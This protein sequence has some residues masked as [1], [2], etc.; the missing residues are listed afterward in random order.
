MESLTMTAIE[1]GSLFWFTGFAV[2]ASMALFLFFLAPKEGTE[3][4]VQWKK[5]LGIIIFLNQAFYWVSSISDGTFTL[6]ESLPLHMCGFSQLMLFVFLCF[7]VRKVF[8]ILV[9]WG[10]LGGIQAFLTPAL[11]SEPTWPYILQ[12]YLAHSFVVLVPIYLM[13][14]GGEKLPSGT[15][16]HTILI[17]N[18]VGFIMMAVNASLGSNYWYV[19]HPPPV[20]HPLVQGGWPFYLIG[21][22]AAIVILFFLFSLAFRRFK[23]V[24]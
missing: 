5:V 13:V 12:F 23:E 3:K 14:R 4:W 9:F 15:F 11:S 2:L 8:P 1:V 10:P 7:D 21:I 24:E 19:N 20:N 6:H 17:T 22:E 16:W 18:I